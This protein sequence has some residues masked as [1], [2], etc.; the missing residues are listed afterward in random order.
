[1]I[2]EIGLAIVEIPL[3]V[4]VK[5]LERRAEGSEVAVLIVAADLGIVAFEVTAILA[6]VVYEQVHQGE[7][8]IVTLGFPFVSLS[9]Y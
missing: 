5:V 7:S 8:D 6:R 3:N 9:I 2:V 4:R 1:M